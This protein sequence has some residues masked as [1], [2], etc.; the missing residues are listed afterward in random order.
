MGNLPTFWRLENFIERLDAWIAVENPSEYVRIIVT[1]WVVTRFDNPYNADFHIT[2]W[3]QGR[4]SRPVRFGT[5]MPC[6][7][8]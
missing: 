7:M 2:S 3:P 4:A 6:G 1:E 5:V 8:G